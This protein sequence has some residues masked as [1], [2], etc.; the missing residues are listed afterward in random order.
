VDLLVVEDQITLK[1]ILP[2]EMVVQ[3]LGE[4]VVV[5]LTTTLPTKVEMVVLV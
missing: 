5:D 1:Q 2:V 3:T 4:V